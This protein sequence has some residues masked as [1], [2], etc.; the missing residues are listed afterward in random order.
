MSRPASL[1]RVLTIRLV[2]VA[3]IAAAVQMAAIL[4]YYAMRQEKTGVEIAL[5]QA[6]A[7]ASN[8]RERPDGSLTVQPDPAFERHY[9][10]Y[11]SDYAIEVVDGHGRIVYALNPAL[12]GQLQLGLEVQPDLWTK[13]EIKEGERFRVTVQRFDLRA[14]SFWIAFAIRHDPAGLYARQM[15]DEMFDHVVEPMLPLFAL[16]LIVVFVVIRRSLRPLREAADAAARLDPRDHHMRLP[17]GALPEEVAGLVS[18]INQSLERLQDTFETQRQF[19]ATAAHELRT[20]LAVLTLEL[21]RMSGPTLPALRADI[22]HMTRLVNQLLLVARLDALPSPAFAGIDMAEIA[23]SVVSRL[24]PLAIPQGK[25]LEVV[26]AG[27]AHGRGDA[28]MLADALRNVVENAMRH[29]PSASVVRITAGPGPRFVVEDAG[30]GISPEDR[31]R[32]NQRL[33]VSPKRS[34]SGAGLGLF[35]VGKILRA[36]GGTVE[37]GTSALGGA[38]VELRL[39]AESAADDAAHAASPPT[40]AQPADPAAASLPAFRT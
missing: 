35:I 40:A 26:A 11:A 1:T 2:I 12:L 32:L 37:I 3:A 10:E 19:L 28:D 39:A 7:V 5:H 38:R 9:A 16:M 31:A 34:G 13:V 14:T 20:P 30:P 27:D 4:V 36:H 29:A 18:T 23:R 21:D 8:V 25:S 15:M 22:E 33:W 6:Q 17:T 24:A